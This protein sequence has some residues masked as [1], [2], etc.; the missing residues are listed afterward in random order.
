MIDQNFCNNH[1]GA[2]VSQSA[3]VAVLGRTM[4][5]YPHTHSNR[6]TMLNKNRKKMRDKAKGTEIENSAEQSSEIARLSIQNV[7]IMSRGE[8]ESWPTSCQ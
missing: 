8:V 5:D 4:Q 2:L 1:F 7:T 3:T 6:I